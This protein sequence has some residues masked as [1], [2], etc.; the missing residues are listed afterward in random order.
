MMCVWNAALCE[1]APCV[2][3][4]VRVNNFTRLAA[5][6]L[7]HSRRV[8]DRFG[9]EWI[10]HR[11]TSSSPRIITI[12]RRRRHLRRRH[13][14]RRKRC[15]DFNACRHK[16]NIDIKTNRFHLLIA[17]FG[18]LSD[19]IRMQMHVFVYEYEYDEYEE[20]PATCAALF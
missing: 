1:R 12:C 20:V 10:F 11:P 9:L 17:L 8:K 2:C 18:I 14:A 19:I 6:S 15:D 7:A 3:G 13:L 5:L 16:I 4:N